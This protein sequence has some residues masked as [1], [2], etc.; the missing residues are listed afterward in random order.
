MRQLAF[1][2]IHPRLDLNVCHLPAVCSHYANT[3]KR[4]ISVYPPIQ[5]SKYNRVRPDIL[6]RLTA[7]LPFLLRRTYCIPTYTAATMESPTHLYAEESTGAS[8]DKSV[9]EASQT[10][11][12]GLDTIDGDTM[13][14]E[15]APHDNPYGS[16]SGQSQPLPDS[17]NN[18]SIGAGEMAIDNQVNAENENGDNRE[19]SIELEVEHGEAPKKK[20]KKR[21]K[22]KSKRGAVR[23]SPFPTFA[24]AD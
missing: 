7:S 21:S 12:E 20:S 5:S 4:Y 16:G 22:P 8:G 3:E 13:P 11:G 19:P 9:R 10:P 18:K 24:L 17:A 15:P 6:S 1:G 14:I 23:N 2:A